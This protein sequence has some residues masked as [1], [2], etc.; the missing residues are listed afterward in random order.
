ME[1]LLLLTCIFGELSQN[2]DGDT[3]LDDES[4]VDEDDAFGNSSLGDL[5]KNPC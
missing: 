1:M 5:L 3:T 4:D 2:I